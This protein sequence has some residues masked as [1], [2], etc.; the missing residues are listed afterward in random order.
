[1]ALFNLSKEQ[2]EQIKKQREL[3]D[4]SFFKRLRKRLGIAFATIGLAS[5]S[6]AVAEINRQQEKSKD[7][8]AE[9]VKT[10]D[11]GE[12]GADEALKN[13]GIQIEEE[14]PIPERV[15]NNVPD[16]VIDNKQDSVEQISN[17]DLKTN[18]RK[19]VMKD[20]FGNI[21]KR[22]YLKT[23]YEDL[24]RGDI[25]EDLSTKKIDESIQD[26]SVVQ[27][28]QPVQT[29]QTVQ[30]TPEQ[31]TA[32]SQEQVVIPTTSEQ[33]SS[34]KQGVTLVGLNCT[35]NNVPGG[36]LNETNCI[37]KN[38]YVDTSLFS[39]WAS[40]SDGT[41]VLDP[42]GFEWL[43]GVDVTTEDGKPA[44]KYVP[45]MVKYKFGDVELTAGCEVPVFGKELGREEKDNVQEALDTNGGIVSSDVA[46]NIQE[47]VDEEIKKAEEEKEEIKN[48][49]DN[50]T[51]LDVDIKETPD[52]TEIPEVPSQDSSSETPPE[53]ETTAEE[54][55]T[56]DSSDDDF[57]T[58]EDETTQEKAEEQT[59]AVETTQETAE[60]QT[61][62]VETT[63]K[64]AEEQTQA[65]ETTQETAE[66]QT[67]AV[68][69]AQ[70]KAEEQTQAVE[71]TQET[72]EEQTQATE[73]IEGLEQVDL[74][75]TAAA[76]AYK[77]AVEESNKETQSSSELGALADLVN[78]PEEVVE[79]TQGTT[80]YNDIIPG[81][82]AQ[83]QSN[84]MNR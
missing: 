15:V 57:F 18:N 28:V 51:S 58:P 50:N 41:T 68:E 73:S 21:I 46:N 63:Q 75:Y 29:V 78:S 64:T 72:A 83:E 42:A 70:E 47:N 17:S 32:P 55:V 25:Q 48:E 2:V 60:E 3:A 11:Y 38:G 52:T 33:P 39:V 16:K 10:N 20:D 66:E 65:V 45:D 13:R 4:K 74:D 7:A 62:A 1:M 40:F 49:N 84:D 71:T 61:Q 53:Q 26:Q 9:E 35:W 31:Q 59:Q 37:V 69:T 77:Q 8:Q 82:D 14:M 34:E 44:W 76:E 27:P 22:N 24:T 81:Q 67:Q 36:E 56:V 54:V 23:D 12:V 43:K 80:E 79:Y 30:S 6:A 5:G 19:K